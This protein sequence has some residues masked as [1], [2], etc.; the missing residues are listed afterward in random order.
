MSELEL[1][2]SAQL[3]AE[4]RAHGLNEPDCGLQSYA[5]WELADERTGKLGRHLPMRYLTSALPQR[6]WEAAITGRPIA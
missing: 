6:V 5:G 1:E 3:S 4:A 2:D